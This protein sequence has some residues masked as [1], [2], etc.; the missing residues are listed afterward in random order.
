MKKI[1][2]LLAAVV[3]IG[4]ALSACAPASPTAIIP[5]TAT[6]QIP[7]TSGEQPYEITGEFNYTN[8]IITDYYV[9]HAVALVDMY[10]FVKRDKEWEIPVASQTLGYLK[11]DKDNMKGTYTLQLPAKPSGQF[12][13]VDNNGEENP[14]VQ[15]FAVSYWPNLTGGPYSEGDDRSR[16]WPTYL[17]SVKTD[18]ENED[19]VIGG[20]LV[21]WAPDAS[22]QFPTG[23]GADGKLFTDDDPVGPIPSGYS[24]VNLDSNPFTV[25]QVTQPKLELFEPKDVAIKD[26][27][28]DTYTKAFDKMFNLVKLEYAFNGIEGKQPEWD[29]VYAEIKP[30]VEEAEKNSDPKAFFLAL[31]DLHLCLQ[32]W[33]CGDERRRHRESDFRGNYGRRFW[34]RTK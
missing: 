20:S 5:T 33:A 16:G 29:K 25:S 28:G 26:Y 8:S 17:A 22:Q 11:I 9:E 3:A 13:D 23:F 21:V 32:G 4:M 10:G 7:A 24:I 31:R 1:F 18:T 14:G 30:R 27:S 34:F 2:S 15:V 19:E 6:G 12:V